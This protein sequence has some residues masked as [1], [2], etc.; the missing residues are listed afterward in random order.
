MYI[1]KIAQELASHH[2]GDS[3]YVHHSDGSTKK[4]FMIAV[5][6]TFGFAI[7]E[8]IGGLVSNSL[9]LL[10]D[11]GH[12][13]TDSF[14][15]FMAMMA[16]IMARRPAGP[17]YSYGYA[18]IEVLSALLNAIM[19][20]AVVGWIIFEAIERFEHPTPVHGAGVFVV[21]TMGLIVNIAMAYLLS[22]D[23]KNINTKSAL[24]HVMGD[25]LGSVAAIAAGIII[26]FGGPYQVDPILS[27]FVALLILRSATGVLLKSVKLLLDAV[28]EGVDYD[29]VGEAMEKVKDVASVHD[30]H[31]W[32]MSADHAALSAHLCVEDLEKWPE[33]LETERDL[34]KSK[35]HIG[36]ITLQPEL[37]KKAA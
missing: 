24:V 3:R 21:A 15:L 23:R 6:L 20:F 13:V 36:H 26:Y 32:D 29:E 4:L 35:Y 34:L 14:S 30:L 28:P 27:V 37:I 5:A 7:V 9:A 25:L 17:H 18:K 11:A 22:R 31:I 10:S 16:A 2:D 12:M 1:D 19:M 8:V 33:V